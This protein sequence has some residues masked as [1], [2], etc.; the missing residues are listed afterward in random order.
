MDKKID[1][2]NMGCLAKSISRYILGKKKDSKV[3]E[4]FDIRKGSCGII[5]SIFITFIP[6]FIIYFCELD[7]TSAYITAFAFICIWFITLIIIRNIPADF[8]ANSKDIKFDSIDFVFPAAYIFTNPSKDKNLINSIYQYDVNAFNHDATDKSII[9]N[10][11]NKN[12]DNVMALIIDNK[13]AAFLIFALL[14]NKAT[15]RINKSEIKG[16]NDFQKDDF[17]DIDEAHSLYVCDIVTTEEFMCDMNVRKTILAKAIVS[18]FGVLSCSD[19]IKYIFCRPVTKYGRNIVNKYNFS[20]T[21]NTAA[22]PIYSLSVK[23]IPRSHDDMQQYIAK[24]C[25]K[26]RKRR[27]RQKMKIKARAQAELL[28]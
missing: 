10:L 18:I 7:Q 27:D 23:Y 1:I 14:S 4:F 26:V 24:Y 6:F 11:Y 22:S 16:I 17:V 9:E 13:L 8:H 25:E 28:L 19:R 21:I 2:D 12:V 3:S 5:I 15:I 20:N